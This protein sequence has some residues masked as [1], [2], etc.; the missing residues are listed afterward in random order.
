MNLKRIE[1]T[2]EN[3]LICGKSNVF[4]MNEFTQTWFKCQQ[5]LNNQKEWCKNTARVFGH[6]SKLLDR[7]IFFCWFL[8]N[9]DSLTKS[10]LAKSVGILFITTE[11]HWYW[12]PSFDLQNIWLL[13]QRTSRQRICIQGKK[14]KT[15]CL[16]T[17]QRSLKSYC[18]DSVR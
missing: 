10:I 4:K 17:Q 3:W 6:H 5:D 8:S 15:S 9:P 12:W 7:I 1:K 13:V 18:D 14:I 16:K 2:L 11:S